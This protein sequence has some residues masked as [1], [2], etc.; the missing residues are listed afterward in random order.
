MTP[1]QTFT[2]HGVEIRERI[3]R[4]VGALG[5]AIEALENLEL[6]LGHPSH[7]EPAADLALAD[8]HLEEMYQLLD[9]AG[10]H[11]TSVGDAL[12]RVRLT[13]GGAS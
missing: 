10:D 3:C 5:F 9:A 8:H 13:E 2:P 4:T 6:A 7:G 12:A 11:L 1:A